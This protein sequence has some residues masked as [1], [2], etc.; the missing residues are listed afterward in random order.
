MTRR[1]AISVAAMAV[2]MLASSCA[3]K[4]VMEPAKYRMGS[5]V[6]RNTG[7]L[8]DTRDTFTTTDEQA[9][10]WVSV[11]NAYGSRPFRFKWY[12]PENELVLDSGP[13]PVTDDNLLYK[14]RYVWSTLPIA[15]S[16][17]A[18]MAGKWEVKIFFK[19]KKVETLTF[20]IKER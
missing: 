13:V 12:N 10:A 20:K 6:D 18:L 11:K 16:P 7:T 9:V 15:E 4:I 19:D 5:E 3:T 17:A 1:T 8:V 14:Y 2:L